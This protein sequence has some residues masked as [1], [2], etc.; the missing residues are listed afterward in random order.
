LHQISSPAPFSNI[1][2]PPRDQEKPW[3]QALSIASPFFYDLLPLLR[4]LLIETAM[5]YFFE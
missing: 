3:F 4:V 1:L 5:Q 2:Q